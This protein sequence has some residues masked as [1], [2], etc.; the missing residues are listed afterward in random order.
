MPTTPEEPDTDH[1]ATI[2]DCYARLARYQAALD[3]GAN[4]R[5]VAD[6][7]RAV[8]AERAA[9]LA[10]ASLTPSARRLSEADIAGI[11]A[12][13]GNIADVLATAHPQD[14][15]RIYSELSLQLAYQ[16]A[17]RVVRA[18]ADLDSHNRGDTGCV[19][20]GT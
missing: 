6:W 10:A 2:A 17:Q 9:A 12:A 20:G 15:A 4:P 3:A 1:A 19:R 5:A 13:L 8:Q 7:T 11:V 16:P 14:K 18:E